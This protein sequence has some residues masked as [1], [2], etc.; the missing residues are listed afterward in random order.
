MRTKMTHSVSPTH[1]KTSQQWAPRTQPAHK[2]KPGTPRNFATCIGADSTKFHRTAST[3][4]KLTNP[5]DGQIQNVALVRLACSGWQCSSTLRWLYP[6]GSQVV[7]TSW[8][9]HCLQHTPDHMDQRHTFNSKLSHPPSVRSKALAVCTATLLN[10]G[11]SHTHTSCEARRALE[12]ALE[13]EPEKSC[14]ALV[15]LLPQRGALL[16][17]LLDVY[18]RGLDHGGRNTFR[19]SFRCRSSLS[20]A[21]EKHRAASPEV[22]STSSLHG[23]DGQVQKVLLFQENS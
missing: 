2:A 22:Q 14:V 19:V 16:L 11:L 7:P 12:R 6:V 3:D 4:V 9:W 13:L 10:S 20:N 1:S 21:G 18:F 23:V 15:R 8:H 5:I 17:T